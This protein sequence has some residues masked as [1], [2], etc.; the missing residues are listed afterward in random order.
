VRGAAID[1]LRQVARVA[2]EGLIATWTLLEAEH[3]PGLVTVRV[4]VTLPE[5][6]AVYVIVWMLVALV[7]V[8]L[9]MDQA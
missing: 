1:L 4:N 7:M 8:P 6:P 9:V 5:A 2:G 3:P